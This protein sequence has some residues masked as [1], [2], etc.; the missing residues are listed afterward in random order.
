[1]PEEALGKG[2]CADSADENEREV[3]PDWRPPRVPASGLKPSVA[4][5]RKMFV[6]DSVL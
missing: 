5:Q 1:M 4:L 2:W 3:D 6:Y